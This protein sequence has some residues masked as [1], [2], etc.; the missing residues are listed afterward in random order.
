M[1]RSM[2]FWTLSILVPL[3]FGCGEETANEAVSTDNGKEFTMEILTETRTT[4]Y[5]ADDP[6][7]LEDINT[8]M[9]AGRNAVS[10]MNSQ[11]WHFSAIIDQS[12]IKELA[13]SMRM[14]PPPGASTTGV[15]STANSTG[16]NALLPP[17][18]TTYPKAGFA[19]APAA[20][21][22]A[23]TDGNQFAA[24]LACGNMLLAARAIGYGVKIVAGGASALNTP[25]N[26]TILGV[27]DNM[28][29]IAILIVGN[30]DKSIDLTADGVTGASTRK[31]LSE[32]STIVE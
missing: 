26:R 2:K 21:A 7:P 15:P 9:E 4:Q 6:V 22:V 25:E 20:I 27:P 17:S 16:N 32:V 24:G 23:C 14:G 29:V 31:P 8:I 3:L 5:F 28:A 18:S 10:G 13:G 30:P 1:K 19:D 11:P 12:V